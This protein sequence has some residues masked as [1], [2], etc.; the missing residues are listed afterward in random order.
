MDAIV[1]QANRH[2]A[3]QQGHMYECEKPDPIPH[4]QHVRFIDYLGSCNVRAQRADIMKRWNKNT[5]KRSCKNWCK[6]LIWSRFPLMIKLYFVKFQ[7]WD[8]KNKKTTLFKWEGIKVKEKKASCNITGVSSTD[9][10]DVAWQGYK[11]VIERQLLEF[12]W[13]FTNHKQ[14]WGICQGIAGGPSIKPGEIT[15]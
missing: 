1:L 10:W 13:W 3:V 11:E 9:I 12:S 15:P 4:L 7:S 8:P 5:K 14:F 2:W 6:S